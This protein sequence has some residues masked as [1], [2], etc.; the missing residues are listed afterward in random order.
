MSVIAPLQLCESKER[1]SECCGGES[2]KFITIENKQTPAVGDKENEDGRQC[3]THHREQI[4]AEGNCAERDESAENE[5]KNCKQW[6]ARRM[7]YAKLMGCDNQLRT[8]ASSYSASIL[9]SV[10]KIQTISRSIGRAV[11]N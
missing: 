7:R 3:T 9:K 10:M 8:V 2:D 5:P 6:I 11:V 4:D 1:G